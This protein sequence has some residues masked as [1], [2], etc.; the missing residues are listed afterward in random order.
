LNFYLRD[1][2]QRQAVERLKR[3]SVPIVL[4]AADDFKG[5]F[6]DDYAHVYE[7][8]AAHYR[9][10]GVMAVDGKPRF[11]VLVDSRRQPVRS[12]PYFHLPCFL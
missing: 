5:E 7:Y 6:V 10:A 12:D 8:V 11:R 4:G 3:Q 1:W 9:D 2:Q